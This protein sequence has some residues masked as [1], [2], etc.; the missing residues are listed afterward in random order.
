MQVADRWR[1]ATLMAGALVAGLVISPGPVQGAAL[2][3]IRAGGSDSSHEAVA[4]RSGQSSA[5]AGL[6][7]TAM[8]K[9]DIRAGRVAALAQ[10][11]R[12]S[13]SLSAMSC[14]SAAACMAAASFTTGNTSQPVVAGEQWNGK[15]WTLR[16]MP[17]PKGT[18]SASLTAMSCS[19]AAACMAAASFTT[20]NTSQPVVAG[21]QWNGKTWTLRPMPLP[22]GA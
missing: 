13:G 11:S 7:T 19:S 18:T 3:L 12:R 6:R 1:I 15:T 16:P 21:E 22:K 10:A 20:G 17:L 2:S 5:G 8:R 4:S 14:S 9:L